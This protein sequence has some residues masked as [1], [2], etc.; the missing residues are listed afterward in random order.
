MC[1]VYVKGNIAGII[2]LDWREFDVKGVEILY[3]G[4]RSEYF[5]YGLGCYLLRHIADTVW[6][7]NKDTRRLWVHT[8]TLDHP[9]ALKTYQKAVCK[10]GDL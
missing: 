5:G 1:V 3:F 6:S 7:H 8:C 9:S 4:L 2:V 10:F